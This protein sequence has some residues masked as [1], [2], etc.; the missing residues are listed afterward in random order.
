MADVSSDALLV[1]KQQNP[2]LSDLKKT[3]LKLPPQN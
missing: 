1:Y 3:I 2:L